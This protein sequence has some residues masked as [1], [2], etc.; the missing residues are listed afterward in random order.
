MSLSAKEKER[1]NRAAKRRAGKERAL[2]QITSDMLKG[3]ARG[4][5]ELNHLP[6]WAEDGQTITDI[7]GNLE[8]YFK[9]IRRHRIPKSDVQRRL[10]R[11]F[12]RVSE[13]VMDRTVRDA[14]ATTLADHLFSQYAAFVK[15]KGW[16]RSPRRSSR[17]RTTP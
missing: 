17:V 5:E 11:S 2:G 14:V 15:E 16:E 8:P 6:S 3:V 4:L 9:K 13:F 10:S 1:V 7:E 12:N